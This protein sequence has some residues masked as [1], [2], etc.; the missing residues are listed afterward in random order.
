[1]ANV[2]LSVGDLDTLGGELGQHVGVLIGRV[3]GS[4]DEVALET[5]TI[6]LH[7]S[8][9][10]QVDNSQSLGQLG[11]GV[12]DVVVVVVQLCIRVGGGGGRKGDRDV[13]FSNRRVK[14]AVTVTTAVRKRFVNHV[15]RIALP[16]V[17]GDL[18]G[19]VS[20]HC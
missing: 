16:L 18:V 17:V 4:D 20:G 7:A 19:D 11:A 10:N 1:M 8:T 9:L 13:V 12:L 14:G 15:P 6:D 3:G 5:D 2:Q